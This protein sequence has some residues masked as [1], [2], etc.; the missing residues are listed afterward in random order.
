MLHVCA[1][2]GILQMRG[3]FKLDRICTVAFRQDHQ[4]VAYNG[5]VGS[6]FSRCLRSWEK[7]EREKEFSHMYL[8]LGSGV[9]V[10]VCSCVCICVKKGRNWEREWLDSTICWICSY[11]LMLTT[12]R[13][14]GLLEI[15]SNEFTLLLWSFSTC[16]NLK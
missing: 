7:G 13:G 9:Y 2:C 15:S 10:P 6:V 8:C 3:V 1:V 16:E 14:P 12:V 5:Q 11:L 4:S